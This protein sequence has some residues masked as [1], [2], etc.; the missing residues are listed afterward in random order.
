M[1]AVLAALAVLYILCRIHVT[2]WLYGAPVASVPLAAL[3]LAATLALC[4][5]AVALWVLAVRRDWLRLAVAY[6]PGGT[7]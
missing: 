3:A 5:A 4:G 7:S 2:L 1:R 6:N